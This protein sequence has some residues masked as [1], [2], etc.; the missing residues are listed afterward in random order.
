[1]RSL[2]ISMLASAA[3]LAM[4]SPASAQTVTQGQG[5]NLDTHI[6]A[7]TSSTQDNNVVVFGSTTGVGGQDVIFT[8]NTPIHITDGNGFASISDSTLASDTGIFTSLIINPA[9]LFTALEFNLSLDARSFLQVDY[10]LGGNIFTNAG[11]L[12]Q[13]GNANTGYTITS[14]ATP[15]DAVRITSCATQ[16]ICNTAVGVGAGTGSAIN[17]ERQNSITVAA[18]AAVP[19]PG[20]WAMMLLGFGGIGFSLRRRTRGL[21]AQSA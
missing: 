11:V 2:T 15:F 19:E 5:P 9:P 4:A 13:N 18:V 6:S 14:G 8:G 3:V 12:A 16:A 20:T 21:I 10:S 17:F 7:S 1:M